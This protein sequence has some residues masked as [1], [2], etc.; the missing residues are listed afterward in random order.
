MTSLCQV[1][2]LFWNAGRFNQIISRNIFISSVLSTAVSMTEERS[3]GLWNRLIVSGV[4]QH[5]FLVSHLIE[6]TVMSLIVVFE[7]VPATIFFFFTKLTLNAVVLAT[8]IY[9]VSAFFGMVVGAFFSVIF[10]SFGPAFYS[11]FMFTSP[12]MF[13]CGMKKIIL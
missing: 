7:L 6:G 5:Q 9:V 1:L 3:S 10:K 2:T 11:C 12:L 13:M 4:S 8:L